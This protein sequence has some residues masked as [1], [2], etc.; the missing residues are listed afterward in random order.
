MAR[1]GMIFFSPTFAINPLHFGTCP[2]SDSR[3]YD[4]RYLKCGILFNP[5]PRL[6]TT[7]EIQHINMIDLSSRKSTACQRGQDLLLTLCGGKSR[8]IQLFLTHQRKP[9]HEETTHDLSS[10]MDFWL[11][12]SATS[13]YT[14]YRKLYCGACLWLFLFLFSQIIS[15][16]S[17]TAQDV[18]AVIGRPCG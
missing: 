14:R 6:L 16:V 7:R 18:M 8:K 3:I 12:A 15:K 10:M 2:A 1:F 5:G 9:D 13:G 4:V 11:S 17:L